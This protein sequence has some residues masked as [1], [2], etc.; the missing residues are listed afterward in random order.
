[1]PVRQL[2]LLLSLFCL[3][4]AIIGIAWLAGDEL[5][6]FVP[7][8]HTASNPPTHPGMIIAALFGSLALACWF[9]QAGV[10]FFIVL[11]VGIFL[12]T[13]L[14]VRGFLWIPSIEQYCLTVA[15]IVTSVYAWKEKYYFEE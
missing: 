11:T 5:F 14:S 4:L 3:C 12:G 1:M 8:G 7:S 6:L 13:L 9:R 10:I 15:M 2:A